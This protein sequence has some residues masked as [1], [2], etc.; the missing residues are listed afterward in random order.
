MFDGIYYLISCGA[1]GVFPPRATLFA[2]PPPRQSLQ[3]LHGFLPNKHDALTQC[4]FYVGPP[5]ATLTQRKT[6]IGQHQ[7]LR[8]RPGMIHT[9]NVAS[10]AKLKIWW[11]IRLS[12]YTS[13][14][15]LS[16]F[17]RECEFP[18]IISENVK[19]TSVREY[20]YALRE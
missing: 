1:I 5:S 16:R 4:W 7:L 3:S 10:S 15:V 6:S 19:N 18:R 12:W 20:D 11:L 17:G 14:L 13:S 9:T 2:P 8:S